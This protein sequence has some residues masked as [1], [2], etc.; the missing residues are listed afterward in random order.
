[1]QRIIKF[2]LWMAFWAMGLQTTW[3]FALLG[4]LPP[5][6]GG[7]TWQVSTIGYG[8]AYTESILN[9]GPGGELLWLGDVGGP[10]N[11]GEEYRRN[12]PVLYYAYDQNFSGFFGADGETAVDQAFAIMN[13]L[14]NVDS[15]SA[16]LSEFPLQSQS[17]NST[18]QALY[19]TDIKSVTLHLLVEQLG[20][21]EPERYTWVL[22]DRDVGILCPST[23]TYLVAQRNFDITTSPLN[24]LQYS[25]Y[26]N[27]VLYTY[28]LYEFCANATPLADTLPFPADPLTADQ[29]TAV[30]A[31]NFEPLGFGGVLVGVGG[32]LQFG[33][34]YTGLTRD[35][36]AGLR[37][38]MRTNNVNWESPAAGSLLQY[39]NLA[40][41]Q[42]LWTSNLTALVLAAQTNNPVTLAALFPGLVV[43]S[44]TYYLTNIP[45]PN[46]VS[47][48][49][50]YYGE[51]AGT[52]PHLITVTNGYSPNIINFYTTTFANLVLVTNYYPNSYHTN[53]AAQLVTVNGTPLATNTTIKSITLTNVASGDY[54]LIPPG[55]CGPS[56]ISV[57]A[58]NVT[59]TTNLITSATDSGGNFYS[60]SVVIYST[61]HI[62]AVYPCTLVTNSPGSYQ[63]IQRVRFVRLPDDEVDPLTWNLRH[64]FTTN[65]T[66][67]F[68]NPTNSQLYTQTFQRT[69]TTPDI[70]LTAQ[71]GADGPAGINFNNT[72]VRT[73]PNY[74]VGNILPGL[75][76]PGVINSPSTF[77]YNKVGDIFFN[78]PLSDTNS[79][80]YEVTHFKQL[81]WASFDGRPMTR[82]SMGMAPASRTLKTR[83]WSVFPRQLC[84]MAPITKHMQQPHLLSLAAS[85]RSPGH[86]CR[87]AIFPMA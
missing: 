65:Y 17:F 26:V 52:P 51:P 58:T 82:S 19:L 66:M 41:P 18:A 56:I 60:Q 6:L 78:G 83:W 23:T 43:G 55:T 4:P 24:Q 68:Y 63:G 21:A 48:F 53:T 7:E 44:S 13:S 73:T 45:T 28:L 42:A 14:T 85:H 30:A 36:V 50:N 49:T 1:M 33:G 75:R 72:V 61:N 67:V 37:Y 86:W 20:L 71:D 22:H 27:G 8:L 39:T 84:R 54:Y 16:S 77:T 81:Q 10:H 87:E 25:S 74:D 31:N 11:I 62:F 47:Y 59:T 69:V 35:D 38:L 5:S 2:F 9:V 3:G 32:G 46:I 80:L 15:Y 34:F 12:V 57:L 64:P 40:A 70:L 76:G 79:Y 29:Y